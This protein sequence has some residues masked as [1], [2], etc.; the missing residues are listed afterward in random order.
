MKKEYKATTHEYT[1]MTDLEQGLY[2]ARIIILKKDPKYVE[3]ATFGCCMSNTSYKLFEKGED[4]HDDRHFAV[5]HEESSCPSRFCFLSG[6]KA[7]TG[8]I[9]NGYDYSEVYGEVNH[10]K[11]SC[12][13]MC[14]GRPEFFVSTSKGREH[15]KI[16]FD[17]YNL[18]MGRVYIG[19]NGAPFPKYEI[20]FPFTSK[21][22]FLGSCWR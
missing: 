18:I 1:S 4:I 9:K 14:G 12:T 3:K 11:L 6:M 2:D 10:H 13:A 17:K 15:G 21:Q 20:V 19:E 7:K 8:Y 16:T 5:I 22:S